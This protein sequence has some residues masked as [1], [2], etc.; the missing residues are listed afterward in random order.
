MSKEITNEVESIE[1]LED[2]MAVVAE[3]VAEALEESVKT[4]KTDEAILKLEEAIKASGNAEILD[5]VKQNQELFEIANSLLFRA[6][7]LAAKNDTDV[8]IIAATDGVLFLAEEEY[9]RMLENSAE[10]IKVQIG[11]H[12]PDADINFINEKYDDYVA[13]T[14]LKYIN[15]DEAKKYADAI[16]KRFGNEEAPEA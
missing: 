5:M 3:Q 16:S 6:V 4:G 12:Y 13:K 11:Q 15:K 14:T 9:T 8:F 2:K 7:G 10:T 1:A